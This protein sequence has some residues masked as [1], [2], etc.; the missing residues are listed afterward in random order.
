MRIYDNDIEKLLEEFESEEIKVPD[1]LDDKLNLKLKELKLNP[2]KKWI[3]SSAASILVIGISYITIPSF[4]SFGDSV[5]KYI[6][7]DIGFENAVNNEYSSGENQ[8]IKI[9]NYNISIE[10]I[11]IDTLRIS[12]EAVI[13]GDIKYI[14]DM[15]ANSSLYVEGISFEEISVNNGV[16]Y[17]EDNKLKAN[18]QII[19]DGVSNLIKNKDRLNLKLKLVKYIDTEEE[20]L[21]KTDITIN[22][23]K[24]VQNTKEIKINKVIKDDGLNISIEKLVVSPTMMYMDTSGELEE[25]GN[26][27]GLYNFKILSDNGSMY[28]ES[29]S[30]SGIGKDGGWRQTIIPSVYYDKSKSLNLKAEGVLID[31]NKEIEINLNDTYPKEI[32]YFGHVL[33]IRKV[34]YIDNKLIVEVLEDDN[35]SYAGASSID[36]EYA[37]SGYYISEG[38]YGSRFDIDKRDSYNLNLALILKYNYPIDVKINVIR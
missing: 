12:F 26:I 17:E 15:D 38:W 30:L 14:D 8:K 23:P 21:G 32:D 33:T 28:N 24:D 22:I 36:K 5:F 18:V 4:R 1:K 19:G 37:S 34:E 10:N 35:I 27:Q 25:V 16:F 11:Y 29:L 31:A 7:S 20:I 9:G 6:F 3:V 2:Y 13:L